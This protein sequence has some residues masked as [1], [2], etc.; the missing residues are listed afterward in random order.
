MGALHLTDDNFKKEI[1]ESKIPCM[2]DFWAEWCGP[3]K[4]IG[5]TVEELAVEFAGKCK[6]V[7]LNID[8]GQKTASAYGVMSIPTLLFFKNGVV[9]GQIVGTVA[10]AELQSKIEEC[11]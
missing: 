7:K 8:D 10:K 2:V 9:I 1:L 11:L 6:V 4:R 3:C 5:P